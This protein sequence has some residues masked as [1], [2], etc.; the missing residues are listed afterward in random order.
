MEASAWMNAAG[1]DEK[2]RGE[3]LTIEEIVKLA[4]AIE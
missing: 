4:D 3:K 1:L 2:I